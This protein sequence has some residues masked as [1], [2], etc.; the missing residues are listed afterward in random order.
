M[1]PPTGGSKELIPNNSI[2]EE[3]SLTKREKKRKTYKIQQRIESDHFPQLIKIRKE[4]NRLPT[5][6]I[7]ISAPVTYDTKKGKWKGPDLD[8]VMEEVYRSA[9]TNKELKETLRTQEQKDHT[10]GERVIAWRSK[11]SKHPE[12]D[13]M[14]A[15]VLVSGEQEK[16][17]GERTKEGQESQR[18]P[19]ATAATLICHR[20]PQ[21]VVE[22]IIQLCSAAIG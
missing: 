16:E 19:L 7:I 18:D 3:S 9:G 10:K 11:D 5:A 13:R 14:E 2:V 12:I 1:G 8:K 4:W 21:E 22:S 17:S 6:N 15:G 20:A